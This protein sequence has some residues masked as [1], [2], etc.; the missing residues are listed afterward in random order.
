MMKKRFQRLG[1]LAAIGSGAG[2]AAAVLCS[3][4]SRGN[5][6]SAVLANLSPLPIMIAMLGYGTLA[7]ALAVV[8]AAITVSVLFYAQ[9]KFGN[10]D[11]AA[12]AGLTFAF[13]VALPAFW[14]SLLSVLSRVKGSPNWVVTSRV[15]SFF[16]REYCP[17]ERVLS[18]A[19]SV[20]A[21]IGVA[22]AIYVSSIYG[23]FEVTLE[24]LTA[25]ITP[26]IEQ[27][28]GTKMQLP[29]GVDVRT[30]AR[31]TILA[32]APMVAGC[33]LIMF[34]L[35]LWL[36]GR[37]AQLS[38][39][40]PR[41]WPDVAWELRLPRTYLLVFGLTSAAG[42]FFG[43]LPGLITLIVAVT[44]G[45]AYALIGLAVAHYLPRGSSF[46]IPL[47]IVIYLGLAVPVTWFVFLL[48]L[49]VLGIL[50]SAFSLRDR[51]KTASLPKP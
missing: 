23:G 29:A 45:V 25:D 1:S 35:N 15:G 38:G 30:V 11:T 20:C 27:L 44:L 9:E 24:H 22:I 18:Y 21:T 46:R 43:G 7:G 28:I 6:V 12:L 5:V 4:A 37:V 51:K 16:A 42:P 32:G 31:T 49:V 10:V 14:L 33:S 36:A 41:P 2:I 40:L 19:T 13:F 17:L 50:D 3:L 34:M 8:S 26:I 47:L 48:A 39:Q